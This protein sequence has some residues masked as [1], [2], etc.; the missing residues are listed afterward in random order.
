MNE[1]SFKIHFLDKKTSTYTTTWRLRCIQ[2]H[3]LALLNTS[4]RMYMYIYIL[5]TNVIYILDSGNILNM[6]E[7]KKCWNKISQKDRYWH[8]KIHCLALDLLCAAVL[9]TIFFRLVYFLKL[10]YFPG[11][12]FPSLLFSWALSIH[13]C[14][15]K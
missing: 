7:I 2:L 10:V 11:L 9:G 5:E 14:V 6:F 8:S 12:L 15:C 13:T 3:R 1:I 4:A